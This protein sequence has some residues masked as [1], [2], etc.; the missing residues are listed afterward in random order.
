MTASRVMLFGLLLCGCID[1]DAAYREVEARLADGGAPDAGLADAGATD[2]GAEDGGRGDAGR[3]DSGVPD[4]GTTDGGGG[5]AGQSDAGGVDGGSDGGVRCGFDYCLVGSLKSPEYTW[6]VDYYMA[7]G[8]IVAASLTNFVVSST[9]GDGSMHPATQLTW[10]RDGVFQE[11]DA[12]PFLG[13]R[14]MGLAGTPDDLWLANADRVRHFVNRHEAN[15]RIGSCGSSLYGLSWTSLGPVA[16]GGA[17]ICVVEVNDAG[18]QLY[19]QSVD[20][21]FYSAATTSSGALYAVGGV[22]SLAVPLVHVVNQGDVALPAL[23]TDNEGWGAQAVSAAGDDV[24]VAVRST[25]SMAEGKLLHQVP[26]ESFHVSYQPAGRIFDVH[27]VA[28]NDVWAVGDDAH[29]PI[30]HFDG[31]TWSVIQAQALGAA[32]LWEHIHGFDGGFI[33]SGR[34]NSGPLAEKYV[35]VIQVYRREGT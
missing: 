13:S 4:S 8:G 29:G 18:T 2:A 26:G 17:S 33:V 16:L 35:T 6:L 25:S 20:P 22:G 7:T 27:A 21:Y 31:T 28:R 24:F 11:Q 19:H 10:Y 14:S 15:E 23:G 5:D 32:S 30:V 34:K 9:V 12:T 3:A 1:F